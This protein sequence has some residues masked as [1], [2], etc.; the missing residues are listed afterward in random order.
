[1]KKLADVVEKVHAGGDMLELYNSLVEEY[2]DD[3]EKLKNDVKGYI[4]NNLRPIIEGIG[5]DILDR[6]ALRVAL[7]EKVA[8]ARTFSE[9]SLFD[10]SREAELLDDA[11]NKTK[12]YNEISLDGM[13]MHD[14]LLLILSIC[15]ERQGEWHEKIISDLKNKKVS[16]SVSNKRISEDIRPEINP[17]SH[18][19][20]NEFEKAM[21]F[22]LYSYPNFLKNYSNHPYSSD[23]LFERKIVIAEQDFAGWLNAQE[24]KDPTAVVSGF[25]PAGGFHIGYIPIISLIKRFF[26]NGSEI[27]IPIS[28]IEAHATR[29]IAYKDLYENIIHK[30]L[31]N[32]WALG[33][34]LDSDRVHIYGHYSKKEVTS[35]AFDIGTILPLRTLFSTFGV[36]FSRNVTSTFFPAIQIADIIYPQKSKETPVHTLVPCGVDQVPYIR[37]SRDIKVITKFN[38]KKPSILSI[39]YLKGLQSDKMGT[40]KEWYW[41]R[42]DKIPG[43]DSVK[44][45]HFLKSNYDADWVET[46]KIAKT[47]N[48]KTITI[49]D[50]KNVISLNLD[51][52]NTDLNLKFDN[53]KTDKFIV[54]TENGKLNIYKVVEDAIYIDDEP[55]VIKS[56]I[57]GARTGGDVSTAAHKKIGGCPELCNIF[58]WFEF[59]MESS[60]QLNDTHTDCINGKILCRECKGLAVRIIT[61]LVDNI[62]RE[63]NK[64]DIKQIE[65]LDN[66]EIDGLR[67]M[68]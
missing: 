10:P 21:E 66:I 60:K 59:F 63:R 50:G 34:P 18:L 2:A 26:E 68:K 64:I 56:K 55:N 20:G 46:A 39:K 17:S 29:S 27:Y 51:N 49:T 16:L 48:G 35:L 14:I 44:L 53:G 38:I 67:K 8:I 12:R 32:Y 42:W 30:H 37:R 6:V 65:E 31:L 61:E 33:I 19:G 45:T 22:G 62:K 47:D 57:K 15:K 58:N 24:R 11:K 23:R 7:A 54:K 9:D 13:V 41:F 52:E 36:D 40:K 28:D 25:N 43:N 3:K 1:V 4:G 5:P